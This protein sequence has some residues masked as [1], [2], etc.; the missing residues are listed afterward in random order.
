MTSGC[1]GATKLTTPL[2]LGLLSL[3]LSGT[4][5]AQKY[6]GS[7][8]PNFI[9]HTLQ[10]ALSTAYLTNP[11]LR[12]ERAHLR[13]TDEQVPTALAGWRPTVQTGMNLT[14]YDG[15]TNYASS[16]GYLGSS[17]RYQTPDIRAASPLP[18]H[19]IRAEK[20]LLVF[21]PQR[22]RSWQNAPI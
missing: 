5:L 9:P 16:G 14:Y 12:E 11:T 19:S 21:T 22:T 1:N 18:S 15:S 13:A 3:L 20:P 7:G 4:A 2:G 8:S 10:E 6:D 17:R